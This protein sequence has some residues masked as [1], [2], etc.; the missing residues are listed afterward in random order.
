MISWFS[1]KKTNIA[2]STIEEEYIATCSSCIKE[3]WLRNILE[4]FFDAEIDVID[5]LR[6]N[7]SCIKMKKNLVFHD[8]SKHIEVIFHLIQDMV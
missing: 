6:D 2:L 4:G 5:I 1:R 8:K 3:V 7:Q